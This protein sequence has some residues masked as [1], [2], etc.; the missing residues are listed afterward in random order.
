MQQR[1][2]HMAG[3]I[4]LAAAMALTLA[5]SPPAAHAAAGPLCY[6]DKD[7]I[8][9]LNTGNSWTDAYISLQSALTD[10]NCTEIWVAEGVYKPAPAGVRGVSFVIMPGVSVYGGFVGTEVLRTQRNWGTNITILSGDIDSNDTNLDLNDIAETTADIQGANSYHVVLVNG[11]AAPVFYNVILDG[12]IITAGQANSSVGVPDIMGGGFHCAG[13]GAGAICSPS[14]ANLIFSGN[15]AGNSGGGLYNGGNTTGTS[16]PSLLNV[17]FTGNRAQWGGAMYNDGT[18]GGNSSPTLTE[19]RFS[20]NTSTL[21]GGAMYN[22]GT[23]GGS[24]SPNLND[25]TFIVNTAGTD[26]GAIYNN[27]YMGPGASPTLANVTF[28]GNMAQNG[29]AMYNFGYTGISSPLLTNVT[30]SFNQ[31]FN[32]G[33]AIYDNGLFGGLSSPTLTNVILWGDLG[34]VAGNEMVNVGIANPVVSY[35]VVMG[36]CVAIPG[37]I[38]LAGNLSTDPMV[39]PPAN[40]G[41]LTMTMALLAGSSAVD[42]G[43]NTAC[44]GNDQRGASR[45]QLAACDIGA[46]ERR[47]G[48]RADFAEGDAVSD[49]G[50]WRP[51]TGL[52]GILRS[53]VG[54]NYASPFFVTW[55]SP[56]DTATPGDFDGDQIWDPAVRT[57]PAG[58]QSAAYLILLSSTGYNYSMILTI[59]AGW[60]GLGDTP[61][62]GDYNGDK[63]ADPAI[64]RG[65]SGVWIIPLSPTFTSYAF[66][67]WGSSGDTPIAADVDGD[68][69]TDIG[70][71]RPSTGVWGFLLSSAGYSYGSPLFFS[72]GSPTDIPVMADYDGDLLADPA[73]VIPPSGGQ[74]R[75][76]RIILS[77]LGYSAASSVTVPAGWPG[78]GDTPVPADY[79][80]DGLA[81]PGIWRANT[82]VWIIP[83]SSAKYLNYLF[84]AWGASGDQLA[85]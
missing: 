41:G 10:V 31:A 61:V 71:W 75:A 54:F 46:F 59:P 25:V 82:G 50:Y 80:G 68:L 26:G 27:G 1:I 37:N 7:A 12:F 8:L 79:D 13:W 29:G 74:S 57:P 4:V 2:L 28:F 3:K 51:S 18:N 63:I 16:N 20:N 72:W 15:F 64:W 33:G 49:I 38:C 56:T 73:V 36:T 52:W 84:A 48:P 5:G 14:L 43:D 39:A 42:T 40:N 65:N 81:D 6:V 21:E 77:G 55:G 47:P 85:R 53:V 11:I 76:Y 78:L 22:D 62:V 17:T 60:P 19:V 23:Q 70:Y 67:S 30:F 66:Y 83:K 32:S 35:S 24:S 9:G 58:G 44:P 69:Q 45:P 34:M